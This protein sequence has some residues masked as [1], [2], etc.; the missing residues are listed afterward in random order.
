MLIFTDFAGIAII[1]RLVI[2]YATLNYLDDDFMRTNT[3][4][5]EHMM[6]KRSAAAWRGD[7]IT[8]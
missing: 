5:H 6:T 2:F 4:I 1:L 7:R 3:E 8:P